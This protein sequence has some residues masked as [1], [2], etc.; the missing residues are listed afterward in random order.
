MCSSS[1]LPSLGSIFM[2]ITMNTFSGRLLIFISLMSFSDI[3]FHS[4]VWDIFL[5][6]LILSNSLCLYLFI[7]QT[8]TSP[9]QGVV[10]YR[11]CLVEPRSTVPSDHQS[12]RGIPCVSCV[13][14]SAV[15][16]PSVAWG[17]TEL[18]PDLAMS[19]GCTVVGAFLSISTHPYSP[20][21]NK[22][23]GLSTTKEYI[24]QPPM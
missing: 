21:G 22:T 14:L 6:L 16:G 9:S 3:L 17:F 13:C 2:T 23:F 7:K 15:A 5:Y 11:R 8:A 18:V 12:S 20:I 24:S 4:F 1:L 19:H 10:L